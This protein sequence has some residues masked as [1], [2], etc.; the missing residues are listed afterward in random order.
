M[1]LAYRKRSP[2]MKV[3]SARCVTL[4]RALS[5]PPAS[6]KL[7][8]PAGSAPPARDPAFASARCPFLALFQIANS[9]ANSG[10]RGVIPVLLC[11]G[12]SRHLFPVFAFAVAFS[13]LGQTPATLQQ[14]LPKDPRAILEMAAPHY[15]FTSPDLKPWHLKAT[16]QLYDEKGQPTEQGTFEYWWA[17]PGVSRSTWIRPSATYSEWHTPDGKSWYRSNGDEPDFAEFDLERVLIHAL[18]TGIDQ[19]KFQLSRIERTWNDRKVTCVLIGFRAKRFNPR[20]PVAPR[21]PELGKVSTYCFDANLPAL[22]AM[23]VG[24]MEAHLNGVVE[25]QNH[26]WPHETLI[27]QN[28]VKTLKADLNSLGPLDVSPDVLTPPTRAADTASGRLVLPSTDLLGPPVRM[29][30]PKLTVFSH[31][32]KRPAGTVILRITVGRDGN[33]K[34]VKV[35]TAPSPELGDAFVRWISNWQYRPYLVDGKPVEVDAIFRM[36]IMS[37]LP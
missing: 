17:S 29:E 4:L 14:P 31:G 9:R 3:K 27:F 20:Y 25:S 19:S 18:P 5:P 26:Y 6:T 12:M 16:Y 23:I 35:L 15:D 37:A 1:P 33:V 8:A 11:S 28:G 21:E 13:C 34:S 22:L 7:P 24:G 32:A 10:T 2:C 30:T 36:S